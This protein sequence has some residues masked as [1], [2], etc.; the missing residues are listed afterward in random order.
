MWGVGSG[1]RSEGGGGGGG[2]MVGGVPGGGW[3][4][5]MVVRC[6]FKVMVQRS[7]FKDRRRTLASS[8]TIGGSSSS[9]GLAHSLD[10][11]RLWS[12][13][14]APPPAVVPVVLPPSDSV[15]IVRDRCGLDLD[16]RVE[17][18][19]SDLKWSGVEWGGVG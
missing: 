1:V 19:E 10:V 15:S 2:V 9:P 4:G 5:V 16:F 8:Y 3:D 18:G 12:G 13:M 11:F 6:A 14:G 7:V 17:P